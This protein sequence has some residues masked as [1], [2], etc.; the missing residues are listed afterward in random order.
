MAELQL[1][2][3]VEEAH[4]RQEAAAVEEVQ[5]NPQHQVVEGVEEEEAHQLLL[6]AGEAGEEEQHWVEHVEG[7]QVLPVLELEGEVE[8]P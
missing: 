7:E 1:Q 6:L 8:E 3:E 5:Q 2:V 4:H